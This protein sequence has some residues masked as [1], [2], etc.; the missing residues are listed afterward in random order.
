MQSKKLRRLTDYDGLIVDLDGVVWRGKNPI[1][2]NIEALSIALASGVR[3]VFLTNNSTRARYQIA[4]MI[5]ELGINAT[6]DEIVSSSYAAAL[7]VKSRLGSKARIGV[8]GEEGLIAELVAAGIRVYTLDASRLDAI[9]VGLDRNITYTKLSHA[10]RHIS[11]GALLIATNTDKS[12]PSENGMNPGAGSIL[13]LVEE[14]TGRH[15]DFIVGKPNRWIGEVALRVLGVTGDIAV[16]GDRIETDMELAKK[17]GVDGILVLTGASSKP[18][19][20]AWFTVVRDL[21]EIV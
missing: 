19:E 6:E 13:K 12:I 4:E 2:A 14:A 9:V 8:I 16:I 18:S 20:D 10:S 11:Q 1:K 15:P 7:L 17:M 3:L 21:S 5:R